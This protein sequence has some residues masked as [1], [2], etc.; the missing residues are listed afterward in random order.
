MRRDHEVSS[1][2]LQ[3]EL[4]G[5]FFWVVILFLEFFFAALFRFR[6]KFARH[7]SQHS[8]RHPDPWSWSMLERWLVCLQL[9]WR[10]SSIPCSLFSPQL[11]MQ[12]MHSERPAIKQIYGEIM[13]RYVKFCL[14]EISHILLAVQKIRAAVWFHRKKDCWDASRGTL[15]SR[16]S[17]I[18]ALNNVFCNEGLDINRTRRRNK[19][20]RMSWKGIVEDGYRL[21]IQ[22][23]V[24][25]QKY[26]ADSHSGCII[27]PGLHNQSFVDPKAWTYKQWNMDRR[28][29]AVRWSFEELKWTTKISGAVESC[30]PIHECR[31]AKSTIGGLTL[32][33]N[34]RKSAAWWPVYS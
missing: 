28:P 1:K 8:G 21:R 26:I 4:F 30:R 15:L 25:L 22:I 12:V 27:A 33:W 29:L 17:T 13:V 32:D 5:F 18:W 2:S 19:G 34:R 31:L 20:V 10:V 6:I 9:C 24:Y 7:E 14:L 3:P 23:F 16:I 11:E